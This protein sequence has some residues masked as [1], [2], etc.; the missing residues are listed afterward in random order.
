MEAR[1]LGVLAD[2]A[3]DEGRPNGAL[4]MLADM[5]RIDEELGDPDEINIDLVR[6]ARA[7]AVGGNA[8]TAA[9]LLSVRQSTKPDEESGDPSWVAKM[10]RQ[11]LDAARA[12]LDEKAFEEAWQEGLTTTVDDAVREALAVQ[13]ANPVNES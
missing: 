2:V 9:K 10:E 4:I 5:Y 1:A 6:I 7:L 8:R 12:G 3:I 11:A 13:L